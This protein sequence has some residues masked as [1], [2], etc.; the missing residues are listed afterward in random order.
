VT[1]PW[2]LAFTLLAVLVLVTATVVAGLFRRV[3]LVLSD[4]VWESLAADRRLGE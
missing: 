3:V 1:T 2:I 4:V